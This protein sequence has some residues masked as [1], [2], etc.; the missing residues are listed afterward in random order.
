[1]SQERTGPGNKW[2]IIVSVVCSP[3]PRVIWTRLAQPLNERSSMPASEFGQELMIADV[4]V[5]DAGHYQCSA[6]NSLGD[7]VT[8]V[9]S[10]NVQC[11]S[12][13]ITVSHSFRF[14]RVCVTQF[15]FYG[16]LQI[17]LAG[18]ISLVTGALDFDFYKPD[19]FLFL[20]NRLQTTEESRSN[21]SHSSSSVQ[22]H[23]NSFYWLVVYMLY[24]LGFCLFF[25]Y[26]L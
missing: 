14:Y 20:G 18:W 13:T 25:T 1:M 21:S 9:I 12:T 19:V 3:T 15:I 2:I 24:A 7:P 22:L 4:H 10:L 17:K 11:Q 26:N 8:H 5:E 6:S 23:C 16:F